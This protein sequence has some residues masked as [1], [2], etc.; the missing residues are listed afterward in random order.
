MKFITILLALANIA[1]FLLS[2]EMVPGSVQALNSNAYKVINASAMATL[3]LADEAVELKTQ[4]SE[5][6]SIQ[7]TP[8]TQLKVTASG[9]IKENK[10][11]PII[12]PLVENNVLRAATPVIDKSADKNK[13]VVNVLSVTPKVKVMPDE[14][15][16]ALVAK[17]AKPQP[18]R[19]KVENAAVKTIEIKKQAVKIVKK[20]PD[21]AAEIVKLQPVKVKV[22]AAEVKTAKIKEQVV[23][24]EKK[25]LENL[26]CYRLGPYTRQQLLVSARQSLVR[27]KIS[28]RIDQDK[29]AKK[30]KAIR[31]LVDGLTS[32]AQITQTKKRLVS[33]KVDHYVVKIKG[34]DF[35]QVGYFSDQV[36]G[37][38][39]RDKLQRQ[40]LAI[41]ADKIYHGGNNTGTQTWLEL[42]KVASSAV[43]ALNIPKQIKIKQHECR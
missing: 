43:Q 3:T 34:K 13:P 41:K 32:A 37:M 22:E 28:Y 38:K 23:K 18:A 15:Q 35:I 40:G 19:A 20:Q 33:L 26:T 6:S 27:Q 9:V 21:P 31:L 7:E 17:V 29:K 1:A 25:P 11:K 12:K 24:I 39:Y 36:G 5:L 10:P 42:N 14:K 16:L 2:T 4:T 8:L 30:V